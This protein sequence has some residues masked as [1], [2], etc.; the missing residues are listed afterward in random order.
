MVLLIGGALLSLLKGIDYEE[1]LFLLLVAWLLYLRRTDFYRLSFP[2]LSARSFNW[3]LALLLV[4]GGYAILGALIHGESMFES[5][6]WLRF[7]YSQEEPR[8]MRSLLVAVLSTLGF[9][10]WI[11]FR[12]PRPPLTLPDKEQL[13]EAKLF[14]Q[15]YGENCFSHLIFIGDK[16]FFYSRDKR[17]LIQYGRIRDR[18]VALGD[19]S[20]D[21]DAFEE[22]IKEFRDFADCYDLVPVFHEVSDRYLHL[23]HDLGFSLFKLGEMAYVSIADFSLAG[24]KG[25][26][27]RHSFN[28]ATKLGARFELLNPPFD[29]PTWAEVQHISD[30]W[31]AEKSVAEKGFSLGYFDHDYLSCAPLAVVTVEN[32]P[33]A[34]ANLMP[35]YHDKEELS[36]DL[37]RQAHD[38]PP[39]TMDFLFVNVIEYGRSQGYR[40]FNLG[41]APL[42]GVGA[43]R[44]SHTHE[45]L[46]GLAYE[47]GNRLYNYKGLRSF[48]EK[49]HPEWRST[50]LV[51][52]YSTTVGTLLLDTAALIA[53][54]YWKIL[55][56]GKE[57]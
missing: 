50:Y 40:Y 53:G 56:K 17:A 26:S 13:Q 57:E 47:Y 15:K 49:F 37:M 21:E 29:D 8:F 22:A 5:V 23:Y 1:A 11:L 38:A 48:K 4:V 16:Y 19:P 6:H 43:S 41:M 10:G 45:K 52:P 3:L 27:L 39:G 42:S 7:A 14:L 20:G 12:I 31:L 33:V 34:F 18:L 32:R 25:E 46:A 54:G 51:Y 44:Y 28:R 35:S 2:L 30:S 36:I 55:F 24:K 9:L